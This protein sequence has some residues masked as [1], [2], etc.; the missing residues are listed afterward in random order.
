MLELTSESDA[1]C[2]PLDAPGLA[3]LDR[4]WTIRFR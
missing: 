2:R 1:L 3:T 4:K